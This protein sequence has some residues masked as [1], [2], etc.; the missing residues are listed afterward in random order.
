M[1][2]LFILFFAL[3]ATANASEIDSFTNR[4]EPLPD[5]LGAVNRIGNSYLDKALRDANE[6]NHGCKEK[7][8]YKAM[9]EY[10]KNHISGKVTKAILADDEVEKRFFY[11]K[12]SIYRDFNWWNSFVLV[13]VGRFYKKAHGA[14]LNVNGH[15]IG[16]DKFEHLFGRGYMF[17]RR[18]Y[19]KGKSIE[20][21]LK[22]SRWQE[23]WT[24]GSK[25]T[26][27]FSYADQAANFN[28]MRFWN[29]ILQKRMDYLGMN[30]GPIVKCENDEWVKVK[31]LDFAP[32]FDD[33]IDEGLNCSKFSSKRLT[34]KVLYRVSELEEQDGRRYHCPVSQDSIDVLNGKYGSKL[35]PYLFNFAGHAHY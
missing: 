11:L 34:K 5:S 1:K 26:G 8:L 16:T 7:K 15:L 12:D 27:I 6:K 18:Y 25:T 10:F 33:S 14:V 29:H 13:V 28:G 31:D 32:F 2:N 24:L 22:Y 4:Y 35:A 23:K 30:H 17:F 21:T 19:L 20:S 3:L 9:R